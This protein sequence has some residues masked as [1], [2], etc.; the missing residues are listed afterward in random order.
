MF[1]ISEEKPPLPVILKN[2]VVELYDEQKKPSCLKSA[3][4]VVLP[5]YAKLS[6]GLL[7]VPFGHQLANNTY[8]KMSAR[9]AD[10][11]DYCENGE[12]QEWFIPNKF[13]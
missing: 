2:L 6:Q 4:N 7:Y 9:T 5:G 13:W 12:S 10:K 1:K 3:P 8:V 11:S